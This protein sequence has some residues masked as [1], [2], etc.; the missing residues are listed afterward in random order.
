MRK[1]VN[2]IVRIF[3]GVRR[4]LKIAW[5]LLLG[6]GLTAPAIIGGILWGL[7]STWLKI[8]QPGNEAILARIIMFPANFAWTG[9]MSQ[10]P[11]AL[12]GKLLVVIAAPFL[13]VFSVFGLPIMF[14][15]FVEMMLFFIKQILFGQRQVPAFGRKRVSSGRKR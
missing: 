4:S 5:L 1:K 14:L 15:F 10:M 13:Y 11:D 9:V 7:A 6:A 8:T 2:P 3:E 12:I